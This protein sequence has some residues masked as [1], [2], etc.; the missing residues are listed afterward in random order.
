MTAIETLRTNSKFLD[1]LNQF[2]TED[3]VGSLFNRAI[4]EFT[5]GQIAV[6]PDQSNHGTI[7]RAGNSA[8][9]AR[10]RTFI[11][12]LDPIEVAETLKRR[13]SEEKLRTPQQLPSAVEAQQ[14]RLGK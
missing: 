6:S 2:L 9:A 11:D 8:G 12:S 14:R 13:A 10:V 3:E 7:F 1:R 4:T 5:L